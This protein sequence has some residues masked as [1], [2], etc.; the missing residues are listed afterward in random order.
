MKIW[1]MSK[2]YL[3]VYSQLILNLK[4]CAYMKVLNIFI[5][6]KYTFVLHWRIEIYSDWE[7]DICEIWDFLNNVRS[8]IVD[9]IS[10]TFTG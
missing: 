2:M 10:D 4:H 9:Q 6:T 5:N 7:A 1:V 8:S 3:R